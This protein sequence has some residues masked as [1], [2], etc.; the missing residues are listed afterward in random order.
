[1]NRKYKNNLKTLSTDEAVSKIQK[2]FTKLSMDSMP[3]LL[4]SEVYKKLNRLYN[5]ELAGMMGVYLLGQL[6][7][8]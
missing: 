3:C 2:Q 7:R 6:S 4:V 1:M 5:S 8:K